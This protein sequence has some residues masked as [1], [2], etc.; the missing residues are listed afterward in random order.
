[1]QN[2]LD[3]IATFNE[4][5]ILKEYLTPEAFD[6]IISNPPYIP[7]SD[8]A[9]MHENVLNFEPELALF[10]SNDDPLVFY[11]EIGKKASSALKTNGLLF[12]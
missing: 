5:D 12:F 3:P 4:L 6:I 1:M 7:E 9:Q 10:V 2:V 8:K 11:R